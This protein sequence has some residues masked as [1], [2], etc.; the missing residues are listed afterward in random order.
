MMMLMQWWVTLCIKPDMKIE[1]YEIDV[2]SLSA[3]VDLTTL[4]CV[5]NTKQKRSNTLRLDFWQ[6]FQ[7]NRF[8]C[9]GEIMS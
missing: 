7:N 6:I 3:L 9:V 2:I 1:Q 8:V 5:S 4:F